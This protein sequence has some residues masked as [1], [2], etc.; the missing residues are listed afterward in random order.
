[1]LVAFDVIA[2]VR[3]F[4][5]TA[6]TFDDVSGFDLGLASREV[7]KQDLFCIAMLASE[8]KIPLAGGKRTHS[9]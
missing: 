5:K 7:G 4:V 1:M 8:T 9:S 2:I 3:A 6:R